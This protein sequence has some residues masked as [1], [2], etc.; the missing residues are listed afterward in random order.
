MNVPINER[1]LGMRHLIKGKSI[2]K[3][4]EVHFTIFCST[5]KLSLPSRF[6]HL[7]YTVYASLDTLVAYS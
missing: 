3:E 6:K 2:A 4:F 1:P 7:S 5:M